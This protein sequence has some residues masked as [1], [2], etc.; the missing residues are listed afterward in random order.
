L[1]TDVSCFQASVNPEYREFERKLIWT[2]FRK[3]EMTA[4]FIISSKGMSI[5]ALNSEKSVYLDIAFPSMFFSD[6]YRNADFTLNLTSNKSWLPSKTIHRFKESVWAVEGQEF[7]YGLK[8]SNLHF[9]TRLSKNP[10]KPLDFSMIKKDAQF[11]ISSKN[12]YEIIKDS[13]GAQKDDSITIETDSP[14]HVQF[15]CIAFDGFAAYEREWLPGAGES[16]NF[17]GKNSI[18]CGYSWFDILGF[19]GSTRSLFQT[20]TLTYGNNSPLEI[21]ADSNGIELKAYFA[22]QNFQQIECEDC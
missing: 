1:I 8:N 18:N 4:N 16:I 19:L 11:F 17:K 21:K 7:V 6:P 13:S 2:L 15:E 20:M 5:Q 12:L 22:R 3:F 9:R 10:V 14:N